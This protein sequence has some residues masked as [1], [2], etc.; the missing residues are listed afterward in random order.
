[1]SLNK[2]I[3][4]D[5]RYKCPLI[6]VD[7]AGRGALAGPLYAAAVHVPALSSPKRLKLPDWCLEINDSKQLNPQKRQMLSDL[8]KGNFA[9]AIAKV[10]VNEI[11][12]LGLSTANQ[13]A[14]HRAV[15]NLLDS[16]PPTVTYL[17][18][19]D[20]IVRIKTLFQVQ[21]L[22]KGGDGRSFQIACASIL[23][24][25]ARDQALG[26]LHE[27]DPRYNWAQNKGY[28][29]S[30]HFAQIRSHGACKEHRSIF[31]RKLLQR[32]ELPSVQ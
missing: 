1:M 26:K 32:F 10:S 23:A 27:D 16:L 29:T 21:E 13:L 25:V 24:K 7:E 17:I 20:G 28:G 9:Y 22:I 5:R 14:M 31:L 15:M 12:Q 18:L 8:I 3:Q 19:V 30:E 4:F 2:L 11:E 6:G